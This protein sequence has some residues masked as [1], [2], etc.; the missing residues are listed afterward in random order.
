MDRCPVC[1]ARCR[2]QPVCHRCKA[3]LA[4]LLLIEVSAERSARRALHELAA[5][6]IVAAARAAAR[7]CSLHNTPFFESLRTFIDSLES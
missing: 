3:E 6:D 5:G 4:P 1:R 7:A 2:D